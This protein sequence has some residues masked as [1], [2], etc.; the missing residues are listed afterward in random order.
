M[1]SAS[2][3]PNSCRAHTVDAGNSLMERRSDTAKDS[4]RYC[5]NTQLVK[6]K[7][8]IPFVFLL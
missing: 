5:M 4:T 6:A 1:L 2:T 8:A 7:R 3:N